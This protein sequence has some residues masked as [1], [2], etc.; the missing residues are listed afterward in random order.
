MLG[1]NFVIFRVKHTFGPNKF[2]CEHCEESFSSNS[3]LTHHKIK[4]HRK[5]SIQDGFQSNKPK[6]KFR[7]LLNHK[8]WYPKVSLTE[9]F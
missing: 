3:D 9:E 4:V 2:T 7:K 6:K 8:S 5:R 1:N